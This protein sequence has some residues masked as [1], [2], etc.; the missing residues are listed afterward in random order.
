MSKINHILLTG[1]TGFIGH[2][3]LPL[4]LDAG[5]R[6]R[7]TSRRPA[8]QLDIPAHDNLEC[9]QLDLLD[10]R[11]LDGIFA[12]IDT[13]FYLIHSMGGGIGR[14]KEFVERDKQAARNFAGR[15][16]RAGVSQIVYLSGLKPPGQAS[17][18]LESRREVERILS[19][20]DVPLTVLRAGFIIGDGSAGCTMLDALTRTMDTLMVVPE[21]HNRTQP[22][23]VDD[24]VAAMM[25]CMEHR[26]QTCGRTFEVGSREQVTYLELIQL[27]ADCAGRHLEFIDVPWMPRSLG[28]VW[29]SA[30][31]DLPY[32][33]IQAL[34]EGLVTDLPVEDESLYEICELPRTS[35]EEAMRLAV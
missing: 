35:P 34:S 13:A 28:A 25:C 21:F 9:V 8:H 7:A 27:Y 20:G 15:A 4:L 16:A 24:V 3:L 1:A 32:G 2:H 29:L 11:S 19:E 31:S 10:G 23:Y 5:H 18:H 22:A 17:A 6:V 14:E 12:G 30:I 26:D 33:L